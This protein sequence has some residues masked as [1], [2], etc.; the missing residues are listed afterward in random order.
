MLN[1]NSQNL[2]NKSQ[3]P[4]AELWRVVLSFSFGFKD[5]SQ[6][7]IDA[8]ADYVY[9]NKKSFFSSEIKAVKDKS[10]NEKKQCVVS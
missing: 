2:V 8:F 1:P 10:D 7:R 4:V 5:D 6:D 3:I 9:E